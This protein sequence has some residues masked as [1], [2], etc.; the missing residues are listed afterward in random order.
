V[1]FNDTYR[2]VPNVPSAQSFFDPTGILFWVL[3]I[4]VIATVAIVFYYV[5]QKKVLRKKHEITSPVID[6]IERSIRDSFE[7][8]GSYKEQMQK[9]IIGMM[10][11]IFVPLVLGTVVGVVV[12]FSVILPIPLYIFPLSTKF[13]F[14]A[15]LCGGTVGAS[16]GVSISIMGGLKDRAQ[17]M[18]S[19]KVYMELLIV[20]EFGIFTPILFIVSVKKIEEIVKEVI[21][22]AGKTKVHFHRYLVEYGLT[23]PYNKIIMDLPIFEWHKSFTETFTTDVAL[24]WVFLRV[25]GTYAIG[26]YSGKVQYGHEEF[27]LVTLTMTPRFNRLAYEYRWRKVS[28]RIEEVEKEVVEAV[29]KVG[30]GGE[31]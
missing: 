28:E 14:L 22:V 5:M 1:G 2:H 31:E 13:I 30:N 15:I 11:F 16:F 8:L 24:N 26:I 23:E 21:T 19:D 9:A 7:S 20:D 27:P 18:I 17:N 3:I 4:F 6:K 25:R 12:W 29:A 10:L